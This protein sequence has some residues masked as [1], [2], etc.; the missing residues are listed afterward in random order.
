MY[1]GIFM[2]DYIVYI[3]G[4]FDGVEYFNSVWSFNFMIKEWKEKVFMNVKR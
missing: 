1:Y 2:I 3:I 4:G